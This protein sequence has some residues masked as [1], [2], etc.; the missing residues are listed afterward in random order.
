MTIKSILSL[1]LL[2]LVISGVSLN[3]SAA[4]I[5]SSFKKSKIKLYK[6]V[7]QNKGQTFYVGCIWNKKKVDLASCGLEN[8]FS[9]KHK[10]RALRTE[11]EHI[12]P[13]SWLYKKNGKY[14]PCYLNAKAQ[15]ISA[16][17][18]CQIE[19]SEYRKAHNDLVNLRPAVGA[20]N[21]A[22]SNKPFSESV[23]G[24]KVTTYNGN[25]KRITITSRVAI[26]DNSLRGDIARVALY[27][28]KTY[29][30]TYSKR[31]ISL[32]TKWG[33]E[34]PVSTEEKAL[35]NKINSIQGTR[36]LSK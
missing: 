4:Q 23:S 17:K 9:S 10:K 25:G 6:S 22:R 20:I 7:Y 3:I 18:L 16:R 21:A 12:I 34:D 2:T 15:K 13:A 24:K 5:P 8:S 36:F 29:G 33:S 31:Q 27:M 19:D 35:A 11:A 32:F 1:F 26:P 30:A 14:R 28:Q